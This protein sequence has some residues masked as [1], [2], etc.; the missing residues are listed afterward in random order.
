MPPRLKM[1]SADILIEYG[2]IIPRRVVGAARSRR[3]A[4]MGPYLSPTPE[5]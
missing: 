3:E 1:L 5:R 2:E 4:R